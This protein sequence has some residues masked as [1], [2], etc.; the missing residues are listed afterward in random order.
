PG[1]TEKMSGI[2][3]A[4]AK[5]MS[6]SNDNIPH[7][8]IFDEVVV[9]KMWDHRKKY[10]ELAA[11]KGVHLTFLAYVTKALAVVLKEFPIF[12]SQVDMDNKQ[13]IFKDYINIGIATDTD[14]GLFVPN[15]KHADQQRL[16]VISISISDITEE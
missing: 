10:K 2:R 1:H 3:F 8:H 9:D 7:V 5:A 13:S 14:R 15:V 4:T 12:N 11:S 6:R 16:F